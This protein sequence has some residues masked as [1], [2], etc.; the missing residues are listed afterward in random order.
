MVMMT[1][2]ILTMM[3]MIVVVMMSWQ[4]EAPGFEPGMVPLRIT[5]VRQVQI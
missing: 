4:K 1:L 3:T 2:T 5:P